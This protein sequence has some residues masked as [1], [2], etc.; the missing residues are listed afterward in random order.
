[1]A[2]SLVWNVIQVKQNTLEAAR[3]QARAAFEKDVIYRRWNAGHGGVYVPVSEETQPNPY[4]INIPERDITMPSGRQ[5]TLMNPAFMTRQ[6]HELAEEEYGVRGHITSLNPIRPENASDPWETEALRAFEDGETEISSVE[7]MDGEGYMRLMRPLI[8]EKGCLKCHAAQGYQAGDIRGGIRVSVP[9]EPLLT[10]SRMHVLTLALGH[11]LLWLV[12][13]GG[14]VLGTRRLMRS[15]WERKWAEEELKKYAEQLK[16][17]NIRLQEADRLKSVFLATMSHELR[18][19]LNSIIGFTG[20]VLQGLAGPLNDEQTK[21]LG[22]VRNSSRHLLDLINDVLDISKIEAGQLE[23]TSE[24]FD[25][26]EAIEK[27]VRTVTPLAEKKGLALVAE[28]SPEVGQITSDRRRVEQAL[29]NLVNNAIKF[30]EEGEVRIECQVNDG[31]LV[32]RVVDTGIGIKPEDVGKLFE[33]FQQIDT[34]L[35]RVKEGTGLGL[36][37]CKKLLEMLGGEIWVE[38]E[39]GVGSTFTFTLPS[40]VSLRGTLR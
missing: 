30:T 33:A 16:Q 36:S 29:I 1:M 10:I 39:W 25:M 8:T 31:W 21:Q 9:M 26:R 2:A 34:G 18:T 15:E 35:A 22:M 4:L 20:I 12:G 7:E 5:L 32:T 3:I 14:I 27:V 38:S 40:G 17:A 37:I 24:P 23:I 28:V 13:L 11:V 19:P 6:V